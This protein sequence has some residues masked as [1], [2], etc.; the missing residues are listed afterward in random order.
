MTTMHMNNIN[1]PTGG[2]TFGPSTPFILFQP[3]NLLSFITL[4]SPIILVTLLLSAS[5]FFQ[6]VKG[7]V[8]LAFLILVITI[9]SFILQTAGAEKNKTDGCG[10]IKYTSY[11]NT[12]FTTFV[13]AFTIMYLFLPMYQNSNPNWVMVILLIVYLLLDIGI[14]VLQGCLKLPQNMPDIVGDFVGGS[15]VG[16]LAISLMYAINNKD[17]LFFVDGTQ[18]GTMCSMP[19]KQTFK[20]QVFKNG[21]L[22]SSTTT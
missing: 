10:F 22:V 11:G 6:N 3:F 18:N 7:F 4:F 15:L 9:R 21:E 20:C 19:K 5:F 14:K 16:A 13:F 17:N 8:Y 2:Q 1:N 12:T